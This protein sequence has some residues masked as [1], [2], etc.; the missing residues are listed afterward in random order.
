MHVRI[1]VLKGIHVSKNR[2]IN[3]SYF[4]KF[5]CAGFALSRQGTCRY[6]HYTEM[7]RINSYES[8]CYCLLFYLFTISH[9][10]HFFITSFVFSFVF[11]AGFAKTNKPTS[12]F[13]E[14]LIPETPKTHGQKPT[15]L[16]TI[17]NTRILFIVIIFSEVI[18]FNYQ[19]IFKYVNCSR[20]ANKSLNFRFLVYFKCSCVLG[21]NSIFLSK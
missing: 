15:L 3:F 8:L 4:P 2:L 20:N 14:F 21:S 9:S 19:S 7:F 13:L 11:Y 16:R 1:Q 10:L 5:E 18:L 12:G 17:L 6:I